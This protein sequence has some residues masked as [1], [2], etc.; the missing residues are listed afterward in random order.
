MPQ[1]GMAKNTNNR[2]RSRLAT[3]NRKVR[4]VLPSPFKI[5][6]SILAMYMK[7]H[8]KLSVRIKLPASSEWKSRRPASLP[9]T[10]N[11][12]VKKKPSRRQRRIEV[13]MARRTA[14]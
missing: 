3:L 14:F 7:G 6:L 1:R 5:L 2:R 11:R 9:N 8:R 10:R 12:A 13:K 4:M